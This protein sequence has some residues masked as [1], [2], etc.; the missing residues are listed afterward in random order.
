MKSKKNNKKVK[1]IIS[2]FMAIILIFSV[3]LTLCASFIRFVFLNADTYLKVFNDKG[4]EEKIFERIEENLNHVLTVNNLP[5]IML[6]GVISKEEVKEQV[7][8]Y[9]VSVVNYMKTGKNDVEP[10][11]T[12]VYI[13]RLSE[14]IYRY[15]E[16]SSEEI[17]NKL[18][19]DINNLKGS[20][21]TIVK[22]EM[23]LISSDIV[24]YSSKV[25]KFSSIISKFSDNSY[26]IFYALILS[27]SDCLILLWF[28]NIRIGFR[29][30]S[31]S[32]MDAGIIVTLIFFSGYISKFYDYIIIY[33]PYLEELIGEIIKQD[34]IWLLNSG[35]ITLVIGILMY[36]SNF[37]IARKRKRVVSCSES[38]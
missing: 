4:T 35:V 5:N 18:T 15:F 12:K 24:I 3:I 32:L 31:N 22:N 27:V 29:W 19:N 10:I 11:N 38:V 25:S 16:E 2:F 37:V 14:N 28:K 1:N 26:W 23:E 36:G 33:I 8:N 9:L 7:D 17:D 30:I 21:N 20:M 6:E 13:N 34:I